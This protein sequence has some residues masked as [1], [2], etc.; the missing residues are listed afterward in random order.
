M[1]ANVKSRKLVYVA[2]PEFVID[3][4][5][6]T[7]LGTDLYRLEANEDEEGM[8]RLE[9]VFLNWG[10]AT[11]SA[12]PDYLYFDGQILDFGKGME[13]YAG[14]E[15]NRDKIFSGIIT[16]IKG[17]FS[18]LRPPELIIYAE[19]Q[20]QWLRMRNRSR[21]YED[22]TENDMAADISRD[23]SFNADTDAEAPTHDEFL[24][25]NQSDLGF[26][27]E[28]AR[29]I[30]TRLELKGNQLLFLNRRNSSE[31]PVKLSRDTELLRFQV[32]A[33]LTHQRTQVRV[34]GYSIENKDG[35]HESAGA[36]VLS[37]EQ[38]GPGRTG[39]QILSTIRS[40]IVEDLHLETPATADEARITA[41]SFMRQRAR[42]FVRA[43]GMTSGT[44]GLHVGS[45]VDIVDIGPWF[46]GVYHIVSVRHTFD[47]RDGLRTLFYGERIDLGGR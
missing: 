9:A 32:C 36:D 46:S 42:R 10:R 5:L 28:R 43:H 24:Q 39:P 19:D 16:G 17:V 25:V 41:R 2:R 15:D 30:D 1:V 7:R 35:I 20:L 8:A 40:E 33:D 31:P 27:R 6:N 29:N 3:G 18:E 22:K 23:Y 11:E 26:L 45:R 14:D 4:Q 44:P 37:D 47:Q 21:Y 13:I 12:S 34:H 38:T